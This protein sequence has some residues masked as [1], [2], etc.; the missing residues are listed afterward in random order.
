MQT[1]HRPRGLPGDCRGLHVA[2]STPYLSPEGPMLSDT[3]YAM[4]QEANP[5][6]QGGSSFH[7]P[8]GWESPTP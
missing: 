5:R 3:P 2:S 4:P 1:G 6:D 7:L 8:A